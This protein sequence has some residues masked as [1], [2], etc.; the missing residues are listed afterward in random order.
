MSSKTIIR[1]A[2]PRRSHNFWITFYKEMIGLVCEDRAVAIEKRAVDIVHQH[3]TK[4]FQA[5]MRSAE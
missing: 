4:V 3:I 5:P 2:P 1:I